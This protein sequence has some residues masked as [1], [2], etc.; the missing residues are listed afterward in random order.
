MRSLIGSTKGGLCG[1]T[2]RA[3]CSNYSIIISHLHVVCTTTRKQSV[4]MVGIIHRQ[5]VASVV[6]SHKGARTSK[7]IGGIGSTFWYA[8]KVGM[9]SRAGRDSHRRFLG[10]GRPRL[11][12][13]LC[14]V[15]MSAPSYGAPEK[16]CQRSYRRSSE[17]L[18]STVDQ[19]SNGLRCLTD[20]RYLI[21]PR[22]RAV[23]SCASRFRSLGAAPSFLAPTHPSCD[24]R[25][26]DLALLEVER[27]VSRHLLLVAA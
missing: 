1:D 12:R 9:T 7:I 8:I 4:V 26:H 16:G 27:P 15:K 18:D 20:V 3:S 6:S 19:R 2:S 11:K 25:H 14:L 24:G 13:A 23:R 17:K 21:R 10:A 5:N 22:P